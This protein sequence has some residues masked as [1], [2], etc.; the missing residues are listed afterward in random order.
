MEK[1]LDVENCRAFLHQLN[2]DMTVLKGLIGR[3]AKNEDLMSDGSPAK[4]YVEK[5]SD[6]IKQVVKNIQAFRSSLE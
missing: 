5:S 6:R 1:N 4:D 3:M 2:N